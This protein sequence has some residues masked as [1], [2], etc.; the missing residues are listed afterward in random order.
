MMVSASPLLVRSL[1]VVRDSPSVRVS[2]GRGVAGCWES[3][4]REAPS[5]CYLV[6]GASG[7]QNIPSLT[8]TAPRAIS[9]TDDV[10]GLGGGRVSE[11]I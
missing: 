11:S 7:H 6:L 9:L 4:M 10:I 1:F 2:D 3:E 5:G 8:D